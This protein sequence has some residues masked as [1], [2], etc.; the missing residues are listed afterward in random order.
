[1]AEI[2][3]G[4]FAFDDIRPG[5]ERQ[6]WWDVTHRLSAMEHWSAMELCSAR[7]RSGGRC[8]RPAGHGTEHSGIGRCKLH[9]GSTPA[10]SE[11]ARREL[12]HRELALLGGSI[13]IEPTDALLECVHRAAG[14]A[15]WLRLKVES[16]EPDALVCVGA[17]GD[18]ALHTW[19]RMEHEALDRLARWSKMALD[20]GVAERSVQ[21]AERTAQL[22]AVALDEALAPLGLPPQQRSSVIERFA[23]RLSQLERKGEASPQ[24]TI[25]T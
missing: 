17:H 7:T 3:S 12:A 24:M 25:R 22:I 4:L 18:P 2:P 19:A 13:A 14:Q 6:L 1:M 5:L 11:R 8:R 10:Q 9:G 23:E 20:A 21:I 15:T 16:L